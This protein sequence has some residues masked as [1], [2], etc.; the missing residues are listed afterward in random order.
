[1]GNLGRANEVCVLI[2]GQVV[3]ECVL[4]VFL[5]SFLIDIG[6]IFVTSSA[7]LLGLKRFVNMLLPQNQV[8]TKGIKIFD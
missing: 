3:E 2:V 4:I 1:M 6:E 8:S 5:A 7:T